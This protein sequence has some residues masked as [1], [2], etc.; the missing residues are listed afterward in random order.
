MKCSGCGCLAG[1]L[2]NS[3]H[4]LAGCLLHLSGSKKVLLVHPSGENLAIQ[5]RSNASC[6]CS[7]HSSPPRWKLHRV[8]QASGKFHMLC[9]WVET[10]FW[11]WFYSQP[12]NKTFRQLMLGMEKKLPNS[13]KKF[14]NVE[15]QNSDSAR[16]R[17]PAF[18][19]GFWLTGLPQ[20]RCQAC[21]NFPLFYT[22]FLLSFL[23]RVTA[24]WERDTL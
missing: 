21:L 14:Q 8:S 5:E 19:R 7:K 16:G 10:F 3:W 20:G 2:D 18:W 9:H 17:Q 12:N 24:F 23:F 15:K 22:S 6:G 11:I 1:W 4:W 13:K